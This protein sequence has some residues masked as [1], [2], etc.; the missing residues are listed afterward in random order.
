MLPRTSR[1]RL[2]DCGEPV[3]LTLNEV[4]SE[5]GVVTRHVYFPTS[6]FVSLVAALDGKPAL[7]VGMVGNEGMLGAQLALGVPTIPLH[8]LVQGGGAA[9]RMTAGAFRKELAR[10]VPL[11]G[12]LNRYVYV[13]MQ[14]LASSAACVRFH[15]IDARLARWLLMTQDRAQS[16][17]FQITHEFLAYM[18]GVRRVGI[19]TAASILQREKLIQYRRGQLQI[20]DRPGLERRACSCYADDCN[21]YSTLFEQTKVSR[22]ISAGTMKRLGGPQ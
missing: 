3:E 2:I 16:A 1:L 19:T 18:L 8:A 11:Q 9:L 5:R 20:L 21:A 13:L 10:S 14:Q 7:E 12:L 15:R 22:V 17:N 6:A 4:L